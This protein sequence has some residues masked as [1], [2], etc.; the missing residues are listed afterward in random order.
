MRR[1]SAGLL[2]AIAA[3][4]A[5]P[6]VAFAQPTPAGTRRGY[7]GASIGA[8][9]TTS[10]FQAPFEVPFYGESSRVETDASWPGAPTLE[11][12]G[13]V[14]VWRELGV[15]ATFT[16]ARRDAE[17]S[18]SAM[19]PH[20]FFF[21]QPRTL[22]AAG[23]TLARTDT[24]LHLGVTWTRAVARR[25]TV[26]AIAGPSVMAVSQDVIAGVAIAE[27]YPYTTVQLSRATVARRSGSA[28]GAH[29]AGDVVFAWTR[30]VGITGG[31]RYSHAAV[32]VE[33]AAGQRTTV[34]LGGVVV[35]GG[36]RWR[37]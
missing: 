10:R 16:R 3:V 17:S 25:L 13:G 6:V 1:R 11:I 33:S 26:A 15:A 21:N 27:S 36:L 24:A 35:R 22:D 28:V 18:V 7:I 5:A 8:M 14:R 31:A 30:R 29:V 20:P 9:V 12:D 2:L 23:P 32:E 34:D 4:L 19:I 37:F